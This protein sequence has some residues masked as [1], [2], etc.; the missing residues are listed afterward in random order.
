MTWLPFHF[1]CFPF[2]F[3][4]FPSFFIVLFPVLCIRGGREKGWVRSFILFLQQAV[5]INYCFYYGGFKANLCI[6]QKL[7]HLPRGFMEG[8]YTG[9]LKSWRI[10]ILQRRSKYNYHLGEKHVKVMNKCLGIIC[11]S[12]SGRCGW[13]NELI[14]G[15]RALKLLSLIPFTIFLTRRLGYV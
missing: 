13:R 1:C 14:M 10:Y 3:T 2:F 4:S 5:L 12:I 8:I 7:E 15:V 9:L 11:L 6:S